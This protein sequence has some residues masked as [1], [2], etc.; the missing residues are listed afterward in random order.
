MANV[1]IY[2]EPGVGGGLPLPRARLL[3]LTVIVGLLALS[4]GRTM[5]GFG[6]AT[7]TGSEPIQTSAVASA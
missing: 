3:A 4:F 1:G 6:S 5:G 7:R 2:R